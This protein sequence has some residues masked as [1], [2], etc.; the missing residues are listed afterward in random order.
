MTRGRGGE[1]GG[2]EPVE[3]DLVRDTHMA[4]I[5]SKDG[6]G[7]RAGSELSSKSSTRKLASKIAGSNQLGTRKLACEPKKIGVFRIRKLFLKKY[8][9]NIFL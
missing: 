1:V 9:Q 3:M 4:G 6:G 2:G 7:D 8:L 5:G